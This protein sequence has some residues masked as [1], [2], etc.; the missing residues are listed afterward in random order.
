MFLVLYCFWQLCSV[1][2]PADDSTAVGVT[3]VAGGHAVILAVACCW[4]HWCYWHSCR[5]LAFFSSWCYHYC[6]WPPATAGVPAVALVT[7]V[8]G[9]LASPL[10]LVS[11]FFLVFVQCTLYILFCKKTLYCRTTAIWPFLKM[12]VIEIA[13]PW[14]NPWAEKVHLLQLPA[15]IKNSVVIRG[16]FYG[17]G[18][19]DPC[20]WPMNP[21]PAIFVLDLQDAN[22]KLFFSA[23]YFFEGTF[24]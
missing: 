19:A 4:R 14:Q 2:V 21:D 16:I 9:V 5:L 7:A 11:L 17:S 20:L 13:S 18:S 6:P 10:I 15:D 1:G 12:L 24:T 22:K 23:Y 3:S 8:A